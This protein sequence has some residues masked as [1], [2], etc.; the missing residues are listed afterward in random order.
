LRS[1]EVSFCQSEFEQPISQQLEARITAYL[2]T[3]PEYAEYTFMYF[4]VETK[5]SF[6]RILEAVADRLWDEV[7]LDES[8]GASLL[9]VSA[10]FGDGTYPVEG[11]CGGG[12]LRAVEV[13]FIGPAQDEMLKAFPLLRY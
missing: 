3:F 6:D 4:R 9:V 7:I 10:G 2:Q 12:E 11:L 13:E 1:R 5:N 8:S